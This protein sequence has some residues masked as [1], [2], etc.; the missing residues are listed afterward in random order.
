MR[1]HMGVEPT[2]PHLLIST[3]HVQH[4]DRVRNLAEIG[5]KMCWR[6][7]PGR[8]KSLSLTCWDLKKHSLT[9]GAD[10]PTTKV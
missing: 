1:Q 3:L 5:L 4:V 10:D 9:E 2:K 6:N 8:Y 7:P